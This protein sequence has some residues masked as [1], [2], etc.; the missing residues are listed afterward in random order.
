MDVG[1]L[2]HVLGAVYRRDVPALPIIP[3]L[4]TFCS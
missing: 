3:I 4:N 2:S 1:Y